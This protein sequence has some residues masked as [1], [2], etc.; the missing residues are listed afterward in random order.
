[1]QSLIVHLV[2]AENRVRAVTVDFRIVGALWD[3]VQNLV[4]SPTCECR[5][6]VPEA[7]ALLCATF[8][9]LQLCRSTLANLWFCS[10]SALR[11]VV[12]E[13]I[14]LEQLGEQLSGACAHA[15]WSHVKAHECRPWNEMADY[16]AKLVD[17]GNE[18]SVIDACLTILSAGPKTAWECVSFANSQTLVR[19][20]TYR[21]VSDGVFVGCCATSVAVVSQ[22]RVSESSHALVGFFQCSDTVRQSGLNAWKLSPWTGRRYSLNNSRKDRCSFM[23]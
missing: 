16:L 7:R 8:C 12:L 1:M 13:S 9:S 17:S 3:P 21:L 2:T 14:L 11:D 18:C 5:P 10:Q 20:A 4:T 15:T 22:A 6:L 23:V 19:L